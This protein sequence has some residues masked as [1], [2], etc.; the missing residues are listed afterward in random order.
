MGVPLHILSQSQR[1]WYA[2]M[3]VA[4]IL[5]DKEITKPETD[6]IKQILPIIKRPE[7]KQELMNRIA[8]KTPPHVFRPPGVPPKVLAAVFIELALVMISDIEFADTERSFLE[9]VALEFRFT[10]EYY[11][12]LLNWCEEGL[13]WKNKQLD[14]ISAVGNVERTIVPVEKLNPLQQRWYAETLIASILSD[15]QLDKAEVR[16]LKMAIALIKDEGQRREVANMVRQNRVPHISKPSGIPKN[17]LVRIFIEVMLII[18]ADESLDKKEQVYLNNLAELCDFSE[19]LTKRLLSWCVQGIKWKKA[20]NPLINRCQINTGKT[21]NG[22]QVIKGEKNETAVFHQDKEADADESF[23]RQDESSASSD[24]DLSDNEK[25]ENKEQDIAATPETEPNQENNSITDFN[26]DCWVCGES[27]SVKFFQLEE[28]SQKPKHNIFGIPIYQLAADGYD[29]VDYNRCKV[30][31]CHSCFFAS[32]Q[33]ELFKLKANSQPP[34]MIHSDIFKDQWKKGIEKNRA[35]LGDSLQELGTI[36]RSLE[37]VVKSYQTAIKAS[38]MLA[39]LNASHEIA[40]H[41][42]TL[43]LTLAQVMMENGQKSDAEKILKQIYI[44]SIELFKTVKNR[45]ITFRSGRLIV[46][47]ALYFEEDKTAER[48]F[49][50]FKKFKE[51]RFEKLTKEDQNLFLRVFGEI[52]R[53]MEQPTSYH[54]ESLKGFMLG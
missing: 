40:W 12:E 33:K 49:D 53:I 6:F 15:Q 20:K 23:I 10:K 4:A 51:K 29:P 2:Q 21:K 36:N 18:S 31:V 14:F 1:Y 45:F 24:N 42:I 16:F 41:T 13:D 7:E 38:T 48:T 39:E 46:L 3:I 27:L 25:Q 35:F 9:S 37:S 54:R 8:T 44:K 52:K 34:K 47:I 17:Y 43:K 30:A 50:F 26:M 19:N 28:R 5:A 32:P 22:F 11:D